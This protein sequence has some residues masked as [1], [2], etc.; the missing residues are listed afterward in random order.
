[1]YTRDTNTV[2]SHF[3]MGLVLEHLVVNRIVIK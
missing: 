2:G 3:T 1:M